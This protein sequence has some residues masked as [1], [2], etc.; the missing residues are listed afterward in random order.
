VLTVPRYAAIEN[1]SMETE[2]GKDKVVKK[3]FV[4]TVSDSGKAVQRPIEVT[5]VN[6]VNIAVKS[7]LKSGETIVVA[8]QNNLRDGMSVTPVQ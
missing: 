3:Y 2:N 4:F 7:G 5:Y 6:Q 8:G 1:T